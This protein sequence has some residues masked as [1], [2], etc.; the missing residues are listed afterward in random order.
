MSR[1][2]EAIHA[3][4]NA[5]IDE[6]VFR[7]QRE[8]R[9]EFEAIHVANA[10]P[11]KRHHLAW[12]VRRIALVAYNHSGEVGRTQWPELSNYRDTAFTNLKS[13]GSFRWVSSEEV[14]SLCNRSGVGLILS[15]LEGANFASGEY[16]FSGLPIISTPSRG[17]RDAFFDPSSTFIV[18]AEARDVEQCV[19]AV[20]ERAFDPTEIAHR[21]VEAAI[22]HR[23]V[24]LNWLGRIAGQNMSRE[25]N[26][27]AWLPS[28]CDKLRHYENLRYP[29]SAPT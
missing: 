24:L 14:N 9:R 21:A 15:E 27:H 11:W 25:A 29:G 6:T 28:F 10:Q 8:R 18:L 22:V 2:L 4:Q 12:G 20:A 19:Q 7:P 17:G 16:R 3:H 1:G 5:F 13:D 26:A 23:E